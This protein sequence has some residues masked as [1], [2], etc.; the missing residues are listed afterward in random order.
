MWLEAAESSHDRV[1]LSKALG[2]LQEAAGN[3]DS[4]EARMLLG[5]ALL[6]SGEDELGE[7]MLQLQ[8]EAS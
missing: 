3:D 8:R 7:R 2:A 1:A 4:S 5:R 6:L